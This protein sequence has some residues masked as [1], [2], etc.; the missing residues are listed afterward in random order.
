MAL[1]LVDQS[2][3]VDALAQVGNAA[4]FTQEPQPVMDVVG[5][6]RQD[7]LKL[8]VVHLAQRQCDEPGKG[9]MWDMCTDLSMASPLYL[10][11]RKLDEHTCFNSNDI[12]C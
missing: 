2:H 4:T 9:G 5:K 10:H 8:F 11:A 6:A 1:D 12:A 3:N 7:T